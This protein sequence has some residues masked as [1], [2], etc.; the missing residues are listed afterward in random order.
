MAAWGLLAASRLY[1]VAESEGQSLV[2]TCRLLFVVT[3][4]VCEGV[5]TSVAVARGVS[6]MWVLPKSGI[7]PMSSALA[8]E[9]LSIVLPG[10]FNFFKNK[11][12]FLRAVLSS[13]QS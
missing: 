1:L 2:A 8:C 10:T 6:C 11:L 3:P 7:E 13:Q 12:Y 9:F 5:G 4:L